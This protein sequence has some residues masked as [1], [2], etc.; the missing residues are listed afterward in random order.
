MDEKTKN[1]IIK[2]LTSALTLNINTQIGKEMEKLKEELFSSF[3]S[4]I[5]AIENSL[6][7]SNNAISHVGQKVDDIIEINKRNQNLRLE[8]VPIL[9][10]DDLALYM[11]R[12]SGFLG[13]E[14]VP[15][16]QIYR[17]GKHDKVSTIIIKFPTVFHKQEF[18]NRYLKKP[19]ELTLRIIISS[20]QSDSRCFLSADLCKSQY[21]INKKAVKLMKEGQIKQVRVDHGY[22]MIKS[23][24]NDTFKIFHSTKELDDYLIKKT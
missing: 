5:K 7:E 19:K 10:K 24:T 14:R 13:Y 18:F 2:Q 6:S 20:K 23:S 4:K 15:E 8:R 11:K 12:L 9:E 1:D 17:I 3:G 16:H 22:S 21:E